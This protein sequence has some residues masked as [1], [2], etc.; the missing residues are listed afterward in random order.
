MS[1]KHSLKSLEELSQLS[2]QYPVEAFMFV[3]EG[4]QYT[5]RKT[6]KTS[7][8]GTNHIT[9]RQLCFGLRDYAIHKWGLL[10]L[11]VLG[12][13]NITSTMDF[14]KIVFMMV[15]AGWMAKTDEDKLEDFDN[16]FDFAIEFNCLGQ[17]DFSLQKNPNLYL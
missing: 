9:G 3:R 4:L 12:Q 10:A 2:G 7:Q 17:I 16:V 6:G 11:T 8:E 5:I 15:D 1:K 14:G 13:W